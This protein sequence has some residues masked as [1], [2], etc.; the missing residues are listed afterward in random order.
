[1]SQNE[2]RNPLENVTQIML[3][4]VRVWTRASDEGVN[5]TLPYMDEQSRF[6]ATVELFRYWLTKPENALAYFQETYTIHGKDPLMFTWKEE[7]G[8]AEF[9]VWYGIPTQFCD[10]TGGFRPEQEP[11]LLFFVGGLQEKVEMYRG[12]FLDILPLTQVRL[13]K[14][15]A[16]LNARP[17]QA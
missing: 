15:L 12:A 2:K 11:G 6:Y 3:Q 8:H 5:Q 16:Y 4:W 13:G 10:S 7:Y 14:T 17:M 1:M 9:C